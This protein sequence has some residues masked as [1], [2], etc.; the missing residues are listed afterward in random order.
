MQVILS[1]AKDMQEAKKI[2]KTLLQHRL[3]ACINIIPA[4]T[5][6][7]IWEGEIVEDSEVM[8]IIK[9]IDFHKVQRAIQEIHSYEV[10]EIIAF[11]IDDGSN[12]YLGWIR[13]VLLQ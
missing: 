8:L 1:T 3:A 7:Y 12:Q 5:S 4:I 13:E 10:P 9:A 6:M 11:D 2:A